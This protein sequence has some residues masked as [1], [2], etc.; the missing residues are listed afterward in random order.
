[1]KAGSI[2]KTTDPAPLVATHRTSHVHA[3][4][5]LFNRTLTLGAFVCFTDGTVSQSFPSKLSVICV[6][7]L[8]SLV[9]EAFATCTNFAQTNRALYH[10]RE[11]LIVLQA[12]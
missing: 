9:P 6:C 3:S 11:L 7:A 4:I 8:H 12:D 10:Y 1:M 5:V 2:V